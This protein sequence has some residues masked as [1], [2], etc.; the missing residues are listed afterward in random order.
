MVTQ[1]SFV[2]QWPGGQRQKQYA[3]KGEGNDEIARN[4]CP[5]A[6]PTR[7][8][9]P[10]GTTVLRTARLD[11]CDESSPAGRVARA[12]RSGELALR[13]PGQPLATPGNVVR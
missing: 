9:E 7:V 1:L 11:S 2:R 5:P 10:S 4:L 12:V 13:L 8:R 6:S 3:L